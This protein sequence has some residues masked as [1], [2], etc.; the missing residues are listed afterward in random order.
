MGK[1]K[2]KKK[3][4]SN[5]SPKMKENIFFKH[6]FFNVAVI[7]FM[8][9]LWTLIS[10]FVPSYKWVYHSLAKG[11]LELI[12]NN[13][14]LTLENKWYIKCQEDYKFLNFLNASTPDDAVILFPKNSKFNGSKRLGSGEWELFFLYPRVPVRTEKDIAELNMDVTHVAIID[15]KGH[16]E[17]IPNLKVSK[18]GVYS[19]REGK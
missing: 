9:I 12:K 17:L 2:K 7:F 11:N 3:N 15:G 14:N 18:F 19:I 16:K 4:K 6:F 10:N 5:H 1:K 13:S 8:V